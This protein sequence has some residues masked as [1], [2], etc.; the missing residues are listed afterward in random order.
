MEI[1]DT[2]FSVDG[3]FLFEWVSQINSL[4]NKHSVDPGIN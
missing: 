2:T 1:M 4:Y 3:A